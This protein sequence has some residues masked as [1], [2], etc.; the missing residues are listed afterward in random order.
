MG[1]RAVICFGPFHKDTTG[2]YLHWNGG[3]AS[4]EAFLRAA[5]V[6]DYRKPEEVA[7]M[8]ERCLGEGTSVDVGPIETLDCDNLD[9]GTYILND[10]LKIVGRKFFTR[11]EERDREKTEAIYKQ[12]LEREVE[13][14]RTA[15]SG[16]GCP[17]FTQTEVTASW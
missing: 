14:P 13:V 17:M 2:I 16:S 1:N 3:R 12:C 6:L 15:L 11:R 9:N 4:V 8:I 10:R 7:R 5:R